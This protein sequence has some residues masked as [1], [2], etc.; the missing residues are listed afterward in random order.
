MVDYSRAAIAIVL[1]D[2]K[3]W[4]RSFKIIF[5]IFTL[6]YLSYV[7]LV[8]EG[9]IYVNIVLLGLYVI[10]TVFELLTFKK[11]MKKLKKI[12]VRSYKWSKLVVRGFTLCSMMY[13]IYVAASN[14]DAIS[15]ILATL[16][17]ILWVLEVLLEVLIFV[18]EPKVKL[19]IAGVLTDAR[20]IINT[21]NF[22]KKKDGEININYDEYKKEIA[23]LE[24]RIGE[25]KPVKEKKKSLLT[26][27][28]G[29]K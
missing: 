1:E 14:I 10:Y 22:F 16:T 23:I 6:L 8:E 17:I 12:V 24:K 13:G 11:S 2:L 25:V 5:S 3:K 28:I 7:I 20:P 29:R 4:S 9:N 27:M 15:I 18:I 21:Y 19:V 26:R